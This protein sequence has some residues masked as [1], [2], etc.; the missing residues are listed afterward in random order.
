MINQLLNKSVI[1]ATLAGIGLLAM[2]TVASRA[3]AFDEIKENFSSDLTRGEMISNREHHLSTLKLTNGQKFFKRSPRLIDTR[4]THKTENSSVATYYFTIEVPA[5][6]GAALKS[7]KIEQRE[8]FNE[9]IV[10]KPQKSRAV[11]GETFSRGQPLSLAAIG[12]EESAGTV[13][14]VLAEPIEPGN[15]VT[16]GVKPTRNPPHGGTYLF[17]VTVYPEG[18]ED[19][20]GLY[21]GVGRFHIS[22]N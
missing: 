19:S 15:T 8:N 5:D 14:V 2:T 7:I 20:Q 9:T 18:G 11:M 4:A 21:L 1:G 6:A 13:T 12:G 22:D 10:F 16:I 17:G 3:Y